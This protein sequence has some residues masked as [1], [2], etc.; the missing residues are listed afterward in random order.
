M[1]LLLSSAALL[2]ATTNVSVSPIP[3]WV[4]PCDWN[5]PGRRISKLEA[6]RN[7]LYERQENP[8]LK[9]RFTRLVVLME[10][11]T[12]VQDSGSLTFEFD[13]SY[14]ELLLHRVQIQREG[15]TLERLDPSKVRL[16]QPEPDLE[17]HV[18]TGWQTAVLFV[19]DLRV[20]DVLEYSYTIR[21][22]NP[23]LNGHFSTRLLVQTGVPVDQAR[24]RVLWPFA[25]P[26]YVRQHLSQAEPRKKTYQ[27]GADY[28]WDFMYLEATAY[29]DDQPLSYEPYPYIEL[30]DFADWSRVVEWSLP[31]YPNRDA[32]LPAE[33]QALASRWNTA[34]TNEEQRARLA[35]TFVQDDLRYT[36][37]ELGPDS[38]RPAAPDET[39]RLRY[40]DCKAKARLLCA[41]LRQMKIEAWPAL[42]NSLTREAAAEH[43][44]SPFAF[45]HVIVKL[46]LDG[47]AVWVDPTLSHQGGP[48]WERN[49]ARLGKALV[50]KEGTAALE[51]V[52]V[53]RA[54]TLEH[55]T[56]TFRLKDYTSPA[57]LTIHT[58]Y[59]G[60]QADRMREFL[61]RTDSKE[62]AKDYL[63]FYSKYYPGVG[64]S[65]T[66]E[67]SD[68]RERNLLEVTEHYQVGD[69]WTEN[70]SSRRREAIFYAESLEQFLSAPQTRRRKMPLALPYP[71]RR[72][73]TIFVHLPDNEWQVAPLAT[74]VE[75]DAFILNYRRTL[76]GSTVKF[77][78]ACETKAAALAV[79][80]VPGYLKKL[81]EMQGLL[82]DTLYRSDKMAGGVLAQ[83]NLL[84][85]VIAGF[86]IAAVSAGG[87]WFWRATRLTPATLAAGASPPPI[88][89]S[90]LQGLGGWLIL[91]G[92]GLCASVL[93][94]AVSIA[95]IWEGY[96]SVQT[97]QMFAVPGGESYHPLYGPLLIFEVLGNAALFGL[98]VLTLC[99]FFSKRRQ[100]PK[101]YITFL[102]ANAGFLLIDEIG[103]NAIPLVATASGHEAS[104]TD[105]FRAMFAALIWGSYMLKSRRVKS[106]FVR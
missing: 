105:L 36:G 48:L 87:L 16:I 66:L 106:T 49:I 28:V 23:I 38:Y 20:D 50:V 77:D 76:T 19:E 96:F 98:N 37:I 8:E 63:N 64:E 42:V 29:E 7:L 57:S 70:K 72:E 58:A 91:V 85:I 99:L 35:L 100:F 10:N 32:E 95:R 82:S 88:L 101:V 14:Q 73:Q 30:S 67:I 65:G 71:A 60:R 2:A 15:T 84:M 44:P 24:Y 4:Q 25:R 51:D 13:P 53:S 89:G 54:S 90:E 12:G 22:A 79:G 34:G 1:L 69:L 17:G 56:S 55:V 81:E 97:W 43:L 11:E 3:P 6:T 31:L 103:G 104:R 39:F 33:L 74:N 18:L 46:L 75:C 41:L 9:E 83:L 5:N 94:R 47:Q 59:H 21:G 26:L 78:Y 80:Q 52:P 61:A 40:G 68:Q 93:S 27:Q 92:F 62:L 86:A 45:N 102:A